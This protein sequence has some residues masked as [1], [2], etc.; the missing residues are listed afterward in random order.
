M[1]NPRCLLADDHPALTV[2]ISAYL[3]ENGFTIVGPVADGRRAVSSRPR[4]E[5]RARADRLPDAEARGSRADPS[6]CAGVTGDARSPSTRPKRTR[7]SHT[8]CSRP[9]LSRSSSRRPPSPIS[10]ARSRLR[11]PAAR[12]STR[13]S[14]APPAQQALTQRELD[15]LESARRRAAARG[16]RSAARHQLGDRQNAPAQGMRPA[17]CRPRAPR[18]SQ[19]L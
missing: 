16:D 5:A 3:S 9:A 1:N 14:R 12:T 18:P 15:V 13:P 10:C 19:P 4:N 11:S 17:R 8:R 7:R 2:A 6:P